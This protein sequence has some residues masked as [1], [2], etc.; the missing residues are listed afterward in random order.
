MG[1]KALNEFGFMTEFDKIATRQAQQMSFVN[2]AFKQ[3]L[4]LATK[5][6]AP[7]YS[8]RCD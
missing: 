2:S 3:L 6:E 1:V 4:Y 5:P 8:P 7:Y